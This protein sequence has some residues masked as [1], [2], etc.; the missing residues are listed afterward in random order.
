VNILEQIG[1]GHVVG[2]RFLADRIFRRRA[3]RDDELAHLE[4]TIAF[5]KCR[6]ALVLHCDIVA[7]NHDDD[8]T[9]WFDI[10]CE[11]LPPDIRA[12][13]ARYTRLLEL[14]GLL[15]VDVKDDGTVIARVLK[16]KP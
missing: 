9:H 16:D 3:M 14:R 15:K 8:G 2:D 11:H 10:T 4:R 5:E 1:A 7:L 13:V 12:G 6:N